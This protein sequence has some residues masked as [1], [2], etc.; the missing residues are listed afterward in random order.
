[1]QRDI[2]NG[3]RTKYE[4]KNYYHNIRIAA[5]LNDKKRIAWNTIKNDAI[6]KAL[7]DDRKQGEL[8]R[9]RKKV[10]S[11]QSILNMQPK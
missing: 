11:A 6:I 9:Y 7:I 4:A 2:R 10:S 3:D 5:I 8:E 1:M